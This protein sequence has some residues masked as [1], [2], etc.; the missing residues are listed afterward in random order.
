VVRGTYLWAAE[1]RDFIRRIG[2]VVVREFTNSPYPVTTKVFEVGDV[3][4]VAIGAFPV[5]KNVSRI[6]HRVRD[7]EEPPP[8]SDGATLH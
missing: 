3:G 4:I 1:H 5:A 7:A 2:G 6:D 8:R